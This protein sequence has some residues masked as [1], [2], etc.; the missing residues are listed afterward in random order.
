[1]KSRT[2]LL[3]RNDLTTLCDSIIDPSLSSPVSQRKWGTEATRFHQRRQY[4]SGYYVLRVSNPCSDKDQTDDDDGEDDSNSIVSLLASCQF[5]QSGT[6]VRGPGK[7]PLCHTIQSVLGF[8]LHSPGRSK[9]NKLVSPHVASRPEWAYARRMSIAMTS[10]PTP[11][12]CPNWS[13]G[14]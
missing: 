14:R 12:E 1:M 8:V 4:Y 7:I 6:I 2:S 13:I 5:G 10:K 3:M 9:W 11:S